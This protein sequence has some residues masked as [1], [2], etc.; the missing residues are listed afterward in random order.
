LDEPRYKIGTVAKL[1]GLSPFLLRAWENRYDLLKPQ[2]S[3]TGRRAYTRSDV[4]TLRAVKR[5]LDRGYSIGEVARWSPEQ[6]RAAIDDE[7]GASATRFAPGAAKRTAPHSGE[8]VE[9]SDLFA[10]T[11][12]RLLEAAASFDREAFETTL[13]DVSAAAPFGDIVAKVFMPLLTS[14]GHEWASGD[15]SIASE[16]FVT[17]AIRQRLVAGLQAT[18]LS[19][20]PRAVV[21]SAPGDYHELGALFV[22]YRL[23]REGWAVTFLGANLPA[24]EFADAIARLEP[25]LIGL[26]IV[27]ETSADAIAAWLET[28]GAACPAGARKLCGGAGAE[29]HANLIRSLGFE[30]EY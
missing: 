27:L 23:A 15:M 20:G 30:T 7:A 4:E 29:P 21:A 8:R 9:A 22:A 3:D 10:A 28:I 26:S 24:P 2:R 13:A 18:A 14:V 19:G 25:S 16:H 17:S 12:A 6:I 1:T 5:L 11:R